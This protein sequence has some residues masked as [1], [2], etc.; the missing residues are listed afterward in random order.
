MGVG[1]GVVGWALAWKL[2]GVPA[3]GWGRSDLLEQAAASTKESRH[4]TNVA[5]RRFIQTNCTCSSETDPSRIRKARTT[6]LSL[7]IR[8]TMM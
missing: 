6:E 3:V 5:E 7:S 8:E 2:V 4:R 1:V